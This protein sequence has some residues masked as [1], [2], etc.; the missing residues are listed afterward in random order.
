MACRLG[1]PS[2]C[3]VRVGATASSITNQLYSC[4]GIQY[5]P[6]PGHPRWPRETQS[7]SQRLPSGS[8][9]TAERPPKAW[10]AGADTCRAPARAPPPRPRRPPPAGRRRRPTSPPRGGNLRRRQPLDRRG[11][12]M[13][14][15]HR[16][17]EIEHGQ[18]VR[19]AGAFGPPETAIEAAQGRQVP[20]AED[21]HREVGRHPRPEM[22]SRWRRSCRS[23]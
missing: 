1:S 13:E 16:R 7:T 12:G 10:S 19:C 11:G 23:R 2:A 20:G 4:Q 21:H 5:G 22:P 14:G 18:R 17:P 6:S 3:S 15:E 8:A 9:T